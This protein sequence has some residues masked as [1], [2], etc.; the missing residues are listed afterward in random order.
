M[1]EYE[2]IIAKLKQEG[3]SVIPVELPDPSTL[4]T[5]DGEQAIMPIACKPAVTNMT[6][7]YRLTIN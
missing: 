7:E 2:G 5:V 3:C 4:T 1:E 6:H